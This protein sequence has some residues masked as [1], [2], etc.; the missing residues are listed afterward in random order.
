MQ[1]MRRTM[2]LLVALLSATP[3]AAET[4]TVRAGRL[5]DV[6]TGRALTDQSI[7]VRD[8]RVVSVAPFKAGQTVDIDWSSYTVLP[9]LI[10]MHT[11]LVGDIQS[12]SPTAVVDA[13]EADDALLGAAHARATLHA[14]FTSVRDV[15]SYRAFVD[16]HLRDAIEAGRIPGPRMSV[17]GAYITV[18]EGGGAVTGLPEGVVVPDSMTRGVVRGADEARAKAR[19]ILQHK[20]DFLKLIATGAVLTLGTEPGAQ[21][22]TEAEMRAAVD[23]AERFGA[24]AT[25]HA[26]GAEG[27][28]AAIR[29]GVRSIEHGSLF[30]DKTLRMMKKHGVWLVADIYNGDYIDVVGARDG[31]PEETL[32]KNRETTE[33]QREVFRRAVEMGVRIA[34]GTDA[35]VFP[36]G[37]NAKQ[38]V[39]MVR[40]GMTPMEAI[41]SATISAARLMRAEADVGSIAPG[42]FADM[43][44]VSGDPLADISVLEKV[45]GVMKGGVIITAPAAAA[46]R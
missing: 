44:A 19:N 40:Y 27:G 8:G 5:I 39:Y 15:G 22:L 9:G 14:G 1:A 4:L 37:D 34:Y 21:E 2:I 46:P 28:K 31:W 6:E 33:T 7:L 29:A 20:A 18:P 17:A 32:R 13:T 30:D 25:A 41:R 10:D 11:H 38:F 35:G 26:H 23:E 36:H 43:I 24:Y 16:V 12:A 3:V 45:E 42:R